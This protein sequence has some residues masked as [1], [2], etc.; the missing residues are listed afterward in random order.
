MIYR[1]FGR[2]E[3]RLPVFSCGGMRFQQFWN[4]GERDAVGAESMAN[5]E[6][7]IQRALAVGIHHFETARGYGTSEYQLGR[8]LP[9]LPRDEI[10]V[11]TK[12]GPSENVDDFKR[13][14]DRSFETLQL[15][16]LDL[17]AIHGLN[18]GSL[19]DQALKP[20][21]C[22]EYALQ[23]KAAGRV[24]HV[25]FS[26]HAPL[27]VILRGIDSGGFDY[28]N[29]HWY[30]VDQ[31]NA[32]AL[33]AA[34]QQ[35]MGVF[36]ISPSDK[37]G[38]LYQPSDKLVEL[39]RPLTPMAFND[40]FC[41]RDGQ[42]HT[43]SIGAARP[44]DFDAHLEALPWLGREDELLPEI[45]ARLRAESER[46]LGAEWVASWHVGLPEADQVPGEVNLYHILR[47]YNLAKAYDMLDYGKMRYNLLGGGGH[48]FYG[49]K[50]DPDDLAKLG[51][52]LRDSPVAE[53]IP[54]ALREAHELLAGDEVKRL[55]QGG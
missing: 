51:V 4:D 54:A 13:N 37:G 44:S 9:G 32:P 23:L 14:V 21:G 7:I 33:A 27:E 25:G 11:Q 52:A 5:L 49:N 35:D 26:T 53:R 55:S 8:I 31:R 46:T 6:A 28:V 15:D 42:V 38:K 47:L 19:M 16:Y 50:V 45:E 43:L 2:T 12:V 10:I 18:L 22:L 39:C 24:R 3:L 30:W 41:L 34:H 40:L 20:G 17:F 29:L 36:I 48:W 1:R